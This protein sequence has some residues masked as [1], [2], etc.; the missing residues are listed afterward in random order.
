LQGAGGIGGL[1]ARTSQAYAGA[2]LAGQSYY[3]CDGNGNVTMLINSSNAIV[4]KYLYDAFGNTISKS[5]LLAD[6]NLYRFSSKEAHPNSGLV[7]YL[8]RYYDPN[9]QRWPNRDPIEEAGGANLYEFVGN[10]PP[11]S[12]D[13]F[14]FDRRICFAGHCWIEV[15]T[16]DPN[17][18]VNGSLALNFSP[19]SGKSDYQIYPTNQIPYPHW[20]YCTY[21]SSQQADQ[22]LLNQWKNMQNNPQNYPSWGPFHNCIWCSFKYGQYGIQ[23]PYQPPYSGGAVNVFP[24]ISP[25]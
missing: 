6:A 12:I 21:S 1:L 13:V 23:P 20:T 14:G 16:Y 24:R 9:L 3:H 2:P 10:S 17:G 8:Y 11:D 4:A 22:T 5:G 7:Y 25:R 15:D 19:E 18:N